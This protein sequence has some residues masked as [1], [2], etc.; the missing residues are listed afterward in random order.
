MW[1]RQQLS[2]E[3]RHEFSVAQ[4]M[5]RGFIEMASSERE[6]DAAAEEP[7]RVPNARRRIVVLESRS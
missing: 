6:T 3:V 2:S 7:V 1:N 4:R 5:A